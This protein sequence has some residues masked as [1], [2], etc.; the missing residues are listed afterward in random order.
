MT[1]IELNVIL[2]LMCL[3]KKTR[4]NMIHD[5]DLKYLYDFSTFGIKI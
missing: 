2:K 3:V 5:F 4:V 1:F